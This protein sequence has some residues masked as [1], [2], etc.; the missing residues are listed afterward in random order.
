MAS[1]TFGFPRERHSGT[2]VS[3][4]LRYEPTRRGRGERVRRIEATE[5]D[6]WLRCAAGQTDAAAPATPEE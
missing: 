4:A 1:E 3:V 2:S 6:G 5:G